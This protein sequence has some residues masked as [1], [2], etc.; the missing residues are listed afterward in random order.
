[1][2]V[3]RKLS[4]SLI[5][6]AALFLL[7]CNG[8][9]KEIDN[10]ESKASQEIE[11]RGQ[12]VTDS[13]TLIFFGDAMQHRAQLESARNLGSEENPY[14][15][16]DCFSLIAPVIKEA[17]YAVVN[18]EVPLGGSDYSGFPRFSSPD[19]FALSLR[20]A[21][22][23]L[24]LNANNHMLDRG[25]RG[26][27]RTIS[28]LDSLKVDHIGAYYDDNERKRKVPFIKNINGM[29]IG[30]LNY[31]YATNGISPRDGAVVSLI[32]LKKMSEEI[33]LTRDGGAEFIILLPHWGEEYVMTENR[34]QRALA[35]SLLNMGVDAI[36]GSHPHV[37]QPMKL[38]ENQKTGRQSLV[39]YSLGNFISDMKINNT[40]GGVYLKMTLGRDKKGA[41]SIRNA[42]YDI[43]LTERPMGR[44]TNFRV[45]PSWAIDSLPQNH[46]QY[47]KQHENAV[48]QIFDSNNVNIPRSKNKY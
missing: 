32:N 20:E 8:R 5:I 43:F 40:R 7:G 41:V 4:Y 21:G 27:R 23:D 34:N 28:V 12:D 24:F 44:K 10:S 38:L 3:F 25:D 18:L 1:M 46:I 13:V 36:V 17:D 30:F 45:V 42:E 2:I 26:L 9:D 6:L 47:W 14:N 22:F 48:T 35:D 15:Y 39:A 31:S 11:L 29:K 16:D 37:V 33:K 19:A